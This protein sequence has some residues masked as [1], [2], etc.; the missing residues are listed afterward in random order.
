MVRVH[1]VF[2]FHE[3]G[4]ALREF[5]DRLFAAATFLEYEADEETLVG[6]IVMNIHP[7]ILTHATFLERPRSRKELISVIGLIQEKLSLLEE[8]ETPA[9]RGQFE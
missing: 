2:N 4:Q 8:R 6:R 5:V 7:T 9:S 1:I 3:E